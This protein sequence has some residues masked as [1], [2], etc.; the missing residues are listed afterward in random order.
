MFVFHLD[1][2]SLSSR[3]QYYDD[4]I[5]NLRGCVND[6]MSMKAFLVRHFAVPNE[7]CTTSTIPK[8]YVS[9]TG[10]QSCTR[11]PNAQIVVLLNKA[12]T[13]EAIISNIED[14]L[15]QNKTIPHDTPIVFFFAGHGSRAKAPTEWLSNDG[16]F[17]AICPYDTTAVSQADAEVIHV[18]PDRTLNVLLHALAAKR[19]NNNIVRLL[20]PFCLATN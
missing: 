7:A 3:Q 12:A 8:E 10:E 14:H 16:A 18:I 17:E 15:I 9:T 20:Q 19:K 13:R 1:E 6:A 11:D 5:A 2:F 4:K